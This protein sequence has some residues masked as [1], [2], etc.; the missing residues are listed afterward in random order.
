MATR[1]GTTADETILPLGGEPISVSPPGTW[2]PTKTGTGVGGVGGEV[3]YWRRRA[4][5]AE[6]RCQKLTEE[7]QLALTK[8]A[9]R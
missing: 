9:Q 4:T 1:S 6:A 5:T 3:D 8:L 2:I 7:L